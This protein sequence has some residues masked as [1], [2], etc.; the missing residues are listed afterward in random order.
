MV[1]RVCVILIITFNQVR[2]GSQHR[3]HWLCDPLSITHTTF[4][5]MR[6]YNGAF[7]FCICD[8]SAVPGVRPD[9]TE[10]KTDPTSDPELSPQVTVP[11]LIQ[12]QMIQRGLTK[13]KSPVSLCPFHWQYQQK[14]QQPASASTLCQIIT[15]SELV[16]A[17]FIMLT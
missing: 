10:R 6:L 1:S 2:I 3:K 9:H 8:V 17:D 13:K 15:G 14:C 16:M 12:L 5:D 7:T 4:F 11:Q